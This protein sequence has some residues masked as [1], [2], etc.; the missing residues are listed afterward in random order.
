[1]KINIAKPLELSDG[2]SVTFVRQDNS[3]DILARISYGTRPHSGEW[4][5]SSITGEFLGT[6]DFSRLRNVVSIPKKKAKSNM[7]TKT[8]IAGPLPDQP[9]TL[10]A[11]VTDATKIG[12]YGPFTV[13]GGQVLN[14]RT[15]VFSWFNNSLGLVAVSARTGIKTAEGQQIFDELLANVRATGATIRY[16][17]SIADFM[18][19]EARFEDFVAG[20]GSFRVGY[21]TVEESRLPATLAAVK[22]K[23]VEAFT[24]PALPP[25]PIYVPSSKAVTVNT[26]LTV[27]GNMISN[28]SYRLSLVEAKKAWKIIAPLW[29]KT[30]ESSSRRVLYER[31]Q[32][33]SGDGALRSLRVYANRINIGCQ[34]IYREGIEELVIA[35]G[36]LKLDA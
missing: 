13:K 29:L 22:A 8:K 23:F 21:L 17:S 15:P 30:K 16:I 5:F 11:A 18:N 1:M 35:Q 27:S 34:I 25:V 7:T 9:A 28:G 26:R 4:W 10:T 32:A 24:P 3:G 19:P 20:R 14:G 31:A 12:N 2:R 6:P 36:W 33:I